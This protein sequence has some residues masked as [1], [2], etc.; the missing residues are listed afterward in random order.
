MSYFIFKDIHSDDAK[1]IIEKLPPIVKPAKIYNTVQIEGKPETEYEIIGY[2]PYEKPIPIGFREDNILRVIDWLDGSGRLILSNEP[3]KYY[4]AR[5]LSAINYEQALRFRKANIPF[6]VQPYKYAVNEIA[7]MSTSVINKG[8]V[9]ALP[10]MTITGSGSVGVIINGV[11]ICTVT[12][13]ESI[14]LDS[15]IEEAYKGDDNQNR[16]MVGKFPKLKPGDNV[17]SF[18]GTVTGCSTLVRSRWL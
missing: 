12:I 7:T 18:T 13:S 9:E 2:E 16:Q 14:T 6:W 3:D 11:L 8:N 5:I 15:Q 4:N 17:I 10:L 1:I